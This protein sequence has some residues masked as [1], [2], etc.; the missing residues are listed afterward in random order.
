MSK[1]IKTVLLSSSLALF[2][3]ACEDESTNTL[4]ECETS[5]GKGACDIVAEKDKVVLMTEENRPSFSKKEQCEAQFGVGHCETGV[6]R[7]GSSDMWLPIMMG[8]MMMQN[9]NNND[10]DRR[11]NGGTYFYPNGGYYG[12]SPISTPPSSVISNNTKYSP[13]GGFGSTARGASVSS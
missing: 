5:F 4:K 7:N 10:R 2:T 9:N 12:G 3:T 1:T 13:K 11:S 6:S 8:Y